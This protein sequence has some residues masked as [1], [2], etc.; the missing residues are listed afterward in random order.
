MHEGCDADLYT[1]LNNVERVTDRHDERLKNIEEVA[2]EIRP[3]IKK[4][5]RMTWQSEI[6]M[7]FTISTI[8]F[9]IHHFFK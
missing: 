4:L 1:R 5:Q 3:E 8:V 7:G 2:K 6:R 9:I